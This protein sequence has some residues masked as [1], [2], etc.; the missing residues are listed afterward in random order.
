MPRKTSPK[1]P[2]P[3]PFLQKMSLITV[4][5]CNLNQWALDFDGNLRRIQDSIRQAKAQGA[6]Y[7][8]GPELEVCGYGCEDHFLEQDTF[9]HCNESLAALLQTD[10]TEGI[11]CDIG[12]PVLHHGVRYNCRVF[13]LNRQILLI[14]PKLFMA[15]DGN[16]REGRYFTPWKRS[17]AAL[18]DH[19]LPRVLRKATGQAQVPFGIGAVA[20]QDT[21]IAAETCEELWTPRSPHIEQF[22]GGVEIIGNGSASHHQLRKLDT[23]IDLIVGATAKCGGVYLYANQ[24]GCDGGRLYFD[25]SSLIVCNGKVLAQAP[26]FSVRDVE[27]ITATVDLEDVRSYRAFSSSIREQAS[28]TAAVP[29]VNVPDVSLVYDLAASMEAEEL[30]DNSNCMQHWHGPSAPTP[31]LD[32]S[33]LLHTPEEEC[34]MGPACWLWDYLRRSGA[35]GFLLPLSGGADSSAVAA[36]VGAMCNLVHAAIQEG[37]EGVLA[38]ARRIMGR[39]PDEVGFTPQSPQEI[40]NAILHTV[41]MGTDNS[42]NATRTRA[43]GLATQIG[44]FHYSITIDTIVSAVLGV[45]KLV[46]GQTPRYLTQG[47]GHAEDLALQNIQARLRMVMAY[48]FA[49]LTP[50]VRGKKGF[51]LVLGSA[52]VDEALR[53][54]MTKYDCSSADLNPIG[55]ISKG[56]LK[57]LLHWAAARYGYTVLDEV[58]AAPPT[59]E[60]RPME[61]KSDGDDKGGEHTQ[62]DEED[63]GMSYAELGLY[64]RLRKI[65]RCGPVS[66]FLKLLQAWP[67]LAPAAVAEKVKLFFR[68]Y[69]INRH[70][71]TTLTPAYHAEQYSPDDNRFDLRQFLYPVAWPRQFAAIDRLATQ[72]HRQGGAVP[73]S[74][75]APGSD[76]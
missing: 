40:A 67:H 13:C 21:V 11:L 36:I 4:A 8:L 41:F 56:D 16:Y 58:A 26:Q 24:C 51:L 32:L 17:G 3:P 33:T 42:S 23:R 45:F 68:Y 14:R 20:T 12:M 31:P 48:L 38:D 73:H 15:D 59:A 46:T 10:L 64:G 60:L 52:N 47:G 1:S 75:M 65:E 66:M 5:T 43:A 28:R 44:A 62:T 22:L 39:A 54:Y 63:M 34:G 76:V 69:S 27:V 35:G 2:P 71:L 29:A 74:M 37:N 70:K 57:K 61:G 72:I 50:W 53:G 9:L 49:Q 55:S 7:R 18:E 25:G 19:V 6:R 30:E